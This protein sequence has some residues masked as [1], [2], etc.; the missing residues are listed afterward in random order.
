MNCY[1]CD[2]QQH[3]VPAVAICQYCGIALCRDHLDEDLLAPRTQDLTRRG[4]M[5]SPVHSA[6]V[7][8]GRVPSARIR[9]HE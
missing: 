7:R 8:R 4:C 1:I 9:V 6:H 2:S 3:E 5:H